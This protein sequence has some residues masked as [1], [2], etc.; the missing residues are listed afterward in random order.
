MERFLSSLKSQPI[1]CH[2]KI[3]D[4]WPTAL[5]AETGQRVD[6]DS[7]EVCGKALD[8]ADP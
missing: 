6:T 8:I 4:E 7:Q 5:A 1:E 3:P 2:H